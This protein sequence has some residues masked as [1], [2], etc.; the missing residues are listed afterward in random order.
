MLSIKNLSKKINDK[1]ILNNVSLDVKPGETIVL[2]G[3]SGVGKST[4]LRVLNNLETFDAGTITLN[5]KPLDLKKVNITHTT[6]MLSQHFDLFSHLTAHENIT[7]VLEKIAGMSKKE[8]AKKALELLD[9]YGIKT[10]ANSYPGQLS[11]GQKQRLAIARMVA[12][13]PKII[14]FDE[15]TSALDPALTR[16]VANN[17]K[18]LAEQGY[19]VLVATHDTMLLEHLPCTIHLMHKGNIAQSAAS[20]D[21]WQNREKYHAINSFIAGEEKGI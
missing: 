20:E 16:F 13:Q 5:E 14:C 2:L 18:E 4:L 11:G 9:R 10:L 3:A 8:A 1:T 15:P 6:G 12:L 19:I 21:F 7:L 17:I